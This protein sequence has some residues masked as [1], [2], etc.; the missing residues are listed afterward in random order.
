MYDGRVRSAHRVAWALCHGSLPALHVLHRCDVPLC[1][2]PVHLFLGTQAD[3]MA[4][5]QAKGRRHRLPGETNPNAKLSASQ[6]IA[7]KA[8]E[9]VVP[10][11]DLAQRHGVRA[12]TVLD[13]YKGRT[14]RHLPA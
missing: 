3:N 7:I 10:V 13:I 5:M 9:G 14:W 12:Q 1:V 2:N 6:V 4:D 11:Q 8:L